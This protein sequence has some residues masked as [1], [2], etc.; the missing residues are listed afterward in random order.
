MLYTLFPSIAGREAAGANSEQVQRS[1][2][3]GAENAYVGI[4]R[5][6]LLE[7]Q[8]GSSTRAFPYSYIV[9]TLPLLH[10]LAARRSSRCV[11]GDV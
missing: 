4:K 6:F 7:V 1:N 11:E 9:C 3:G 5:L 2:Q 8:K 10:R